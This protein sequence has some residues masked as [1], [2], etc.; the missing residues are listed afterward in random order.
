VALTNIDFTK[1]DQPLTLT[2]VAQS[3]EALAAFRDALSGEAF[4]DSVQ[5]PASNFTAN[6][7]VNFTITLTLKKDALKNASQ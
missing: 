4:S 2:G 6:A 3:G 7:A 1:E 5:M